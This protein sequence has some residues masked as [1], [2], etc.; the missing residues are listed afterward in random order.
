MNAHRE[1]RQPRVDFF[2]SLSDLASLAKRPPHR[3][4]ASDR[5]RW[6]QLFFRSGAYLD[7]SMLGD[8]LHERY[9]ISERTFDDCFEMGD[10]E[11]VLAEFMP[12]VL[13]DPDL[14]A[15]VR[16]MVGDT[17]LEQWA[18]VSTQHRQ[19]TLF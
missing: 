18:R 14:A 17:A 6:L 13:S 16:H 3:G 11:E 19:P 7:L 15:A 10:S 5:A 2:A 4:K 8:A 12:V 1:S 9:G